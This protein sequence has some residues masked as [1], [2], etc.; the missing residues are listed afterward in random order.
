MSMKNSYRAAWRSPSNIALVKYWGKK[1]RQLPTNPSISFTLDNAFTDT[2]VEINQEP[3]ANK[4]DF[5]FEGKRQG[6]FAKRM[7][8]Y[9]TCIAEE[10]EWV[11][12]YNLSIYS[13]NSFPHSSGIAS[14]ASAF[15]AL[16]LCLTDLH[17]QLGNN[18]ENMLEKASYWAREGSGSACRSIYGGYNLWGRTN[19]LSESS[20][21]IAVN[22]DHIVHPD[23]MK[24]KDT[25]LLVEKGSKSVSSSVGH[26]LLK[27]HP[28][29]DARFQMAHENTAELLSILAS[30]ERE[31]LVQ[32]VEYEALVLH[33]LMMSSHPPFLLMKPGSVSIIEKI[34]DFRNQTGIQLFFTMDAG[35]NVHALYFEDDEKA[36]ME[37][38]DS[39]LVGFCEKGHYLCNAIGQG[40]CKL[41]ADE[42][43]KV[44]IL[45]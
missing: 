17:T 37:F 14:S 31:K 24:L 27:G 23:F 41:T 1:G 3:T 20:D 38:V 25:V 13:S 2:V 22:I 33:S 29:A 40:A 9:F 15:S 16:A 42:A 7:A 19:S 10:F 35:A 32:L 39:E 21:E 45:R 4:L 34:R 8:Q 11:K 18:L 12:D 30:G 44:A 28:F 43:E 6:D 5:Y 26:S 36:V